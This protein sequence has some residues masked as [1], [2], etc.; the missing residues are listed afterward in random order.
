MGILTVY[1][2]GRRRRAEQILPKGVWKQATKQ[3]IA[4]RRTE[5][6]F[7]TSYALLRKGGNLQRLWWSK[8]CVLNSAFFFQRKAWCWRSSSALAKC[9]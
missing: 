5:D 8:W 7:N 4:T 9:L 6:V 3:V 2:G 1:V